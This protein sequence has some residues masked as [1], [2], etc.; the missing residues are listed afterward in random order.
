MASHS[1]ILMAGTGGQG[2]IFVASFIAQCAI[3]QGLNVVQTQTY[4]IAQRGGFIS[5]EVIIS[6]EEILFQQV[7]CPDLIVALHDVVG[8]RYNDVK[9]PVIYDS[10]IMMERSFDNWI[11]IPCTRMAEDMGAPKSANLVA[12][13]AALLCHPFLEL[14]SVIKAANNR[15]TPNIAEM[16]INAVKQGMALADTAL[17]KR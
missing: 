3:V 13:G 8:N 15:F 6:A 17:R 7:Q 1:E 2:L 16:N 11:A 14:D 5:A 9:T 12:F 4:G 10:S